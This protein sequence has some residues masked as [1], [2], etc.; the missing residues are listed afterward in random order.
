MK[1]IY[2]VTDF[3]EN[4]GL[5]GYRRF[6]I[7]LGSTNDGC[8]SSVILTR[9]ILNKVISLILLQGFAAGLVGSPTIT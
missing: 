3:P 9:V 5:N 2:T 6:L 8:K 7:Q 1:A 4:I